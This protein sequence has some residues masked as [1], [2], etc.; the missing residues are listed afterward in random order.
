MNTLA[1]YKSR[2]RSQPM[3]HSRPLIGEVLMPFTLAIFAQ[4]VRDEA[5]IRW[6]VQNQGRLA[7]VVVASMML[8]AVSCLF[9]QA[10]TRKAT[11]GRILAAAVVGFLMTMFSVSMGDGGSGIVATAVIVSV[12]GLA[13]WFIVMTLL[14]WV[15][16]AK[17][18]GTLKNALSTAI[19]TVA[20]RIF[21]GVDKKP[22]PPKGAP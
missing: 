10:E 21:L 11:V 7:V 5:T 8:A 12:S 13:G 19:G 22:D 2:P 15:R 17:D 1:L 3:N 4:S 6:L 9:W 16:E 14:E 18:K 20:N